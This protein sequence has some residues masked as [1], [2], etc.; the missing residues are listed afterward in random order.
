MRVY[1]AS[2]NCIVV[3]LRR[4]KWM[5]RE[6]PDSTT[7]S[8]FLIKTTDPPQDSHKTVLNENVRV[9]ARECVRLRIRVYVCV[10]MCVCLCVCVCVLT[11]IR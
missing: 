2:L 9:R 1:F 10:S 5:W 8:K 7:V 3:L 6:T 4:P 11:S